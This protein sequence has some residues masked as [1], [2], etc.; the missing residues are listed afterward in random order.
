[1]KCFCFY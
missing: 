1:M